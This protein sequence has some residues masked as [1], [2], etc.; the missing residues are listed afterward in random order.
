MEGRGIIPQTRLKFTAPH[1]VSL[2]VPP[3]HRPTGRTTGQRGKRRPVGRCGGGSITA[4]TL[5]THGQSWLWV[6]RVMSILEHNYIIIDGEGKYGKE[7]I[8]GC[9]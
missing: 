3:T 8:K 2:K 5:P 9:S 6:C 4:I 7:S 1:P